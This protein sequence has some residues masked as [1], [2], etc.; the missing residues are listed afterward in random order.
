MAKDPKSRFFPKA[1]VPKKLH[2]KIE[3]LQ[4][5]DIGVSLCQG[6]QHIFDKF[7]FLRVFHAISRPV[8]IFQNRFFC[9]LADGDFVAQETL[10]VSGHGPNTIRHVTQAKPTLSFKINREKTKML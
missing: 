4:I 7:K 6:T 1:H 8:N 5:S 10:I 9:I 2:Y 3:S